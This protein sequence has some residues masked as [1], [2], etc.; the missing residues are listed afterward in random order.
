MR[1]H[2]LKQLLQIATTLKNMSLTNCTLYCNS[3]LSLIEM[4]GYIL[5]SLGFINIK[6]FSLF[7]ETRFL[8]PHPEITPVCFSFSQLY[9]INTT[10][11][12][13]FF[14]RLFRHIIKI[15]HF[16]FFIKHEERS[17]NICIEQFGHHDNKT[18]SN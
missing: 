10:F 6:I 13:T 7:I 5:S 16:L 14:K 4:E 1:F 17:I 2:R 9:P 15:S 3:Y 11:H 12:S 18:I 8:I